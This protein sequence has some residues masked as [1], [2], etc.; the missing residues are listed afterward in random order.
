MTNGSYIT[1]SSIG[2]DF[3]PG[4]LSV[5]DGRRTS[6]VRAATSASVG[7]SASIE[8]PIRS[9]NLW[10]IIETEGGAPESKY[11]QTVVYWPEGNSIICIYGQNKDG[12]YSDEF[13]KFSIDTKSWESYSLDGVTP[14][15]ACGS[16]IV[17]SKLYFYGGI[18]N[19]GFVQDFHVIDLNTFEVSF[20]E[21]TGDAPPKCAQ[22]MMAFHDKYLIVWAGTGGSNLSSLHRLN[23]EYNT[24]E[25]IQTDFVGKQGACGCIIG[26][27]L[28]IYGASSPM[29]ILQ[30]DLDTFEFVSLPTTGTEPHR[31]T[32]CL[33]MIACGNTLV[34]FETNCF[35]ADAKIYIYDEA[36]SNWMSNIVPFTSDQLTSTVPRIVFYLSQ[37]RKLLGLGE[38]NEQQKQP[39]S[40][41]TIGKTISSIN[42]K[43]DFLAA[44]RSTL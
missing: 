38:T 44:L 15:A 25:K 18:T 29:S 35:S 37:E 32:E 5:A 23:I 28:Y 14:R 16:A 36:R 42:Q 8:Q 40:E 21:T 6:S 30:L 34:A 9:H 43:I 24:W 17:N 31:G 1:S 3:L 26:S 19:S 7:Y 22:P 13:W 2:H 10:N 41:L 11:G 12:S 33:T 27:K 20:P 39:L 4:L